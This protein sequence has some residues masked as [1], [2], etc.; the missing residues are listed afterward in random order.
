V[1]ASEF[2]PIIQAQHFYL[3]TF[4]QCLQYLEFLQALH[5]SEPVH[6]DEYNAMRSMAIRRKKIIKAEAESRDV[7]LL[8]PCISSDITR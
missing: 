6:V 8:L 2:R 3:H 4:A 5:G 7:F 1:Y